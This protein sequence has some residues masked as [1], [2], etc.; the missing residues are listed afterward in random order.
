M[1]TESSE[2]AKDSAAKANPYALFALAFWIILV[3]VNL[4]R[5]V[6]WPWDNS[7][8]SYLDYIK[9]HPGIGSLVLSALAAWSAGTSFAGVEHDRF[10]DKAWSPRVVGWAVLGVS[11]VVL[12]LYLLRS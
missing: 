7:L 10:V 11:M 3:A 5:A 1:T 9:D 12:S 6:G 8:S 4:K 2:S